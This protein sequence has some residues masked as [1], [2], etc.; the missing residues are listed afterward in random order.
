MSN[1]LK[2]QSNPVTLRAFAAIAAAEAGIPAASLFRALNNSQWDKPRSLFA[3]ASLYRKA[4]VIFTAATKGNADNTGTITVW[5]RDSAGDVQ[6]LGTSSILAGA[7]NIN[8]PAIE[9]GDL[10]NMSYWVTMTA[11]AG[12]TPAL[13]LKAKLVLY[14]PNLDN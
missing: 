1:L 9:L 11:I 8:F 6:A 12:T 7:T 10:N 2:K 14:N 13:T 4:K 3:G 5:G